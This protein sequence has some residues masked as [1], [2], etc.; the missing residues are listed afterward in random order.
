MYDEAKQRVY[1]NSDKYFAPIPTEVWNYQVGGYQVCHKYLKDRKNRKMDDAPRY[2]RIVTAL[3][4][5]I[6]VQAEIDKLYPGVE[7]NLISF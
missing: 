1:I 7:K 3:A 5:T 6:E 2:C 4:K